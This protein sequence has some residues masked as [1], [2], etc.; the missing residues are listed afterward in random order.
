MRIESL[1][2]VAIAAAAV[3]LVACGPAD[4]PA[5]VEEEEPVEEELPESKVQAA[6]LTNEGKGDFS[7]DICEHYDWYD[8]GECDWFCV[9][10]D[11]DC[12]ADPL[13]PDPQGDATRYPIVLAH[14]FMGSPTNF[15]AFL[16]VADA[17]A[18]D[19]HDVYE[20]EVPP[21]HSV[22]VRAQ[23][24][25]GQVDRVLEETGSDKVNI[26]AHSMGGVDSR[27]LISTLGYGD[28][29]ASLT[30]ISSPHRG[31]G[32]AD[33]VLAVQ[34]GFA[35]DAVDALVRAIGMTFSNEG[36]EAD[37]RASLSSISEENMPIFNEENPDDERVYYQSWAGVSAVTGFRNSETDEACQGKVTIHDG[38]Y[39]HMDGLLWAVVP[40][41]AGVSVVP[42]DGMATAESAIWGDFQGCIPADHLDEVG[43]LSGEPDLD[44]GF[45]HIDFYRTIAFG[46]A[47]RGF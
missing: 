9:R 37:L 17:L 14:G 10:R 24:L 19:G 32:I 1:T 25:S 41:V 5:P 27:Y 29:V 3:V 15:W 31:T 16:N 44:T 6:E 20:G 22:A 47:E 18:E 33:A 36:E 39:D 34:P 26:I 21:F 38:T 11:A 2:F 40:F 45:D 42:N 4:E 12:N 43:Q 28:R 8:D 13:F 23:T 35:D 7:L 30:T 46:L